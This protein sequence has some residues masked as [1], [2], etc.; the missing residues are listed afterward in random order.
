MSV[1]F[2][3]NSLHRVFVAPRPRHPAAD[4]GWRCFS[5]PG[6]FVIFGSPAVCPRVSGSPDT[7]SLQLRSDPTGRV[8]GHRTCASPG[9]P[10]QL[11]SGPLSTCCDS[12]APMSCWSGWLFPGAAHTTIGTRPPPSFLVGYRGYNSEQPGDRGAEDEAR[13]VEGGHPLSGPVP[14]SLHLCQDFL[15]E[16][17]R[18]ALVHVTSPAF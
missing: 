3:N 16:L 1:C 9:T 18:P 2:V 17:P 14:L 7:V 12:R 11:W 6:T 15:P 4:P 13:G 10:G 5:T 8:Q